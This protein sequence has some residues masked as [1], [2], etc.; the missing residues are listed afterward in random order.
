[1]GAD[2]QS[3]GAAGELNRGIQSLTAASCEKRHI[4]SETPSQLVMTTGI[5]VIFHKMR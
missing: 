1:M 2:C 5:I 3:G 4:Y